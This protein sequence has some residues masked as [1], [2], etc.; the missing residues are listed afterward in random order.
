MD[1]TPEQ[2]LADLLA[3]RKGVSVD[4]PFGKLP[5][6]FPDFPARVAFRKEAM[7]AATA[8]LDGAQADLAE[9]QS[10][11]EKALRDALV[12][13]ADF[14]IDEDKAD[15]VFHSAGGYIKGELIE[16]I[17]QLYGLEE[18]PKEAEEL[19]AS[20]TSREDQSGK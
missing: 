11:W 19:F 4:T 2:V 1:K 16:A 12:S 9:V 10:G 20:P 3:N 15:A 18:A 13:C 6:K 5:L 7:K 17:K 8:A 14:E